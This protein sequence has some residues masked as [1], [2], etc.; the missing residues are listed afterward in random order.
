[1]QLV[2]FKFMFIN[3]R[4]KSFYCK[5]DAMTLWLLLPLDPIDKICKG[6]K[7]GLK[8]TIVTHNHH[9]TLW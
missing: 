6:N 8:P 7:S 5:R 2:H 9:P 3:G 1:M 4:L